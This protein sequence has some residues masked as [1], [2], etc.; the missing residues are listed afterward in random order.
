MWGSQAA[1]SV[2]AFAV[3]DAN[4][5]TCYSD[6]FRVGV[7]LVAAFLV[8]ILFYNYFAN[9]RKYRRSRPATD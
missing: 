7:V 6:G 2:V 1:A 9:R 4:A 3:M 5:L 8:F